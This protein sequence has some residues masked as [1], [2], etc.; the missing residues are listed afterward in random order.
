VPQAKPFSISNHSA[1]VVT[2]TAS[3][4]KFTPNA[5]K[6][7]K[8]NVTQ[9]CVSRMHSLCLHSFHYFSA[10]LTSC[11]FYK[12]NLDSEAGNA[13]VRLTLWLVPRQRANI[14]INHNIRYKSVIS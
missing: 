6:E 7:A 5:I 12:L 13:L 2:I 4:K 9:N 1:G 10:T 8:S 11:P 14:M 3:P